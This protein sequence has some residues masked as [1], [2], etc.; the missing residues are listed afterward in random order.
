MNAALQRKEIDMDGRKLESFQALRTFCQEIADAHQC[1][2][3]VTRGLGRRASYF[4]IIPAGSSYGPRLRL[5]D[6]QIDDPQYV[7]HLL[8]TK[9]D[10]MVAKINSIRADLKAHESD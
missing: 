8:D 9:H 1:D 2:M 7:Q 3:K 10:E 4:E 5:N 6:A